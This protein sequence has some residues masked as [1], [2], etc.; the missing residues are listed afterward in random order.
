MCRTVP[1][2]TGFVAALVAVAVMAPGAPAHGRK[3]GGRQ[4][5]PAALIAQ[6]HALFVTNCSPCHGANAEGDDGPSLHHKSLP[7]TFIAAAIKTGFK[8]AMPPFGGKLRAP[9]VKALVAYV[10][11]LQR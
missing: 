9:E 2:M 6:G 11:S 4:A 5:L 3:H 1:L 7:D 10:H 8:G